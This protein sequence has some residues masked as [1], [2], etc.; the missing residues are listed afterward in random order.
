MALVWRDEPEPKKKKN[1]LGGGPSIP[2]PNGVPNIYS[3]NPLTGGPNGVS[4]MGLANP[5]SILQAIMANQQPQYPTYQNAYDPGLLAAYQG[6]NPDSRG[7]D[8][9]RKEALRTG[10]SP[11][12][13]LANEKLDTYR[14]Q[15]LNQIAKGAAGEAAGARTQLAMR[16]GLDSGASERIAKSAARNYL[17]LGQ[18]LRSDVT[19]KRQD[20]AIADEKNRVSQLGALPGMELAWTAPQLEKAKYASQLD[21]QDR[22]GRNAWNMGLYNSQMAAWAAQQQA[23]AIRDS[24]KKGGLFGW[25]FL[26]L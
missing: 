2:S 5:G 17:D 18:E 15:G 1:P 10:P 20:V 21:M 22:A 23:N 12:A 19:G 25:D 26:F 7:M 6:I 16:G 9:F 24:G 3:Q 13:D 14:R 4:T 8:Q 11:W